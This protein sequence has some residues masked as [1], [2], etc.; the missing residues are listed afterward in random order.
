MVIAWH[1][2]ALLTHH[3]ASFPGSVAN[4]QPRRKSM[5]FKITVEFFVDD[6]EMVEAARL[7]EEEEGKPC[8]GTAAAFARD[9]QAFAYDDGGMHGSFQVVSVKPR[10]L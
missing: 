8:P 3:A 9:L 10:D 7:F 6:E 1:G 4:H 5:A 2:A